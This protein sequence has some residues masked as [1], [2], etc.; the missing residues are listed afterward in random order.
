MVLSFRVGVWTWSLFLILI[1]YLLFL[2]LSYVFLDIKLSKFLIGSAP[3]EGGPS[4]FIPIDVAR[5]IKPRFEPLGPA[6][7]HAGAR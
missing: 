3:S 2:L 5:G 4:L 7:W 6:L 1:F